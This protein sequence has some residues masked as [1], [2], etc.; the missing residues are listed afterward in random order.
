MVESTYEKMKEY[1]HFT[2]IDS[3]NLTRAK[4]EAFLLSQAQYESFLE[5]F[6]ALKA[7]KEISPQS[8]LLPLSPQ[9]DSVLELIRVGGRLRQIQTLDPNVIHP[10]AL[11]PKHPTICLL[12]KHCDEQL[13]HPGLERVFAAIRRTYW[14]LCG[15]QAVKQHQWSCIECRKWHAKHTYSKMACLPAGCDYGSLPFGQQML[16]ALAHSASRWGEDKRKDGEF[17]L[18]A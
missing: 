3:S 6:Q 11:D 18:N 5:E 2:S 1:L 9:F 7:G 12:I 13:L 16:T 8:H 10:I 15:R 14:I 4:A 17:N